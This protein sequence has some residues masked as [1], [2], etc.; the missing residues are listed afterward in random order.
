MYSTPSMTT[1]FLFRLHVLS[2]LLQPLMQPS[3]H[4]TMPSSVQAFGGDGS[5]RRPCPPE[6]SWSTPSASSRE[7]ALLLVVL[8]RRKLR[9]SPYPSSHDDRGTWTANIAEQTDGGG[10]SIES[11]KR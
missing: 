3:G 11:V 6:S 7:E 5:R 10:G 4:S 8:G 1:F 9:P 2:E